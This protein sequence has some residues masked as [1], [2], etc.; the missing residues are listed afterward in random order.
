MAN[1]RKIVGWTAVV[2]GGLALLVV[3]AAIVIL[4]NPAFQRYLIARI[5]QSAQQS[6]GARVE[7]QG[8]QIHVKTL[9]ADIYGLTVHGTEPARAKPLLTIPSRTVRLAQAHAKSSN[10]PGTNRRPT[11]CSSLTGRASCSST[12]STWRSA[13]GANSIRRATTTFLGGLDGLEVHRG[14]VYLFTSNAQFGIA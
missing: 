6:T 2:I 1:W 4:H 13:I 14:V 5:E 3:V 7:I 11:N 9:S 8:L 12:T 10:R